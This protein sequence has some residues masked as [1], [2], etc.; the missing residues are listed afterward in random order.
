M[1]IVPNDAWVTANGQAFKDQILDFIA[2]WP[3]LPQNRR[4]DN[5]LNHLAYR[6]EEFGHIFSCR[7]ALKRAFPEAFVVS[8]EAVNLYVLLPSYWFV[9]QLCF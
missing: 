3:N 8:Q 2:T 6:F 7:A 1:I 5:R 4:H 9:E